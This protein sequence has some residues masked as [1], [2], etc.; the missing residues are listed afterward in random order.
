M[1]RRNFLKAGALASIPLLLKG[2]PV[3]AS[4]SLESETLD[5]IARATAGCG[6]IL[7]IVQM[8][9]GNDG[10][11]TVFPLDEWSSLFN[12][13]SNILMNQSS[14]LTLNNNTTTGLH[15][16]MSEMK[17]MY[18]N[19]K[20]MLVQAVSYPNPSFSHFRATD[21][22]FT[23]SD[24]SQTLNSGWIGRALD[25]M[26]PGYP[27]GY[28]TV[29][30]PDPLAIEIGSTLPFCLQGP[31]MNMGYSAPDPNSLLNVIN[32]ITDPAPNSDYG[33][34]LA[35]LRL[36]KDQSNVYRTAIQNAY[37]T[38]QAQSATYP[39]NNSLGDQLKIVAKLINGGLQ[40]PIYI[41]NH[42]KTHDTHENQVDSSDKTQGTHADN[43]KI[44]SQAISAFQRDLELMGKDQI[45]TGMTFSEFGRRIKS[46]ASNGTDHGSSA[47]VIFFGAAL[48]TN[49]ANVA[50]TPYPV[51]G[52][53]GT[54]PLLPASATVND[55][56]PMQFD[57]RQIY[58]T[59]MQDWLCM[60]KAD[61][62]AV[63]GGSFTKLPIF[64]SFVLPVELLFFTGKAEGSVAVLQW[65]TASEKNNY[66]FEIERSSNAVEFVKIGELL[67]VGTTTVEHD[68]TFIDELPLTGINYYRL[69]QIDENGTVNYSQIISVFFGDKSTL[70]IFPNPATDKITVQVQSNTTSGF[71]Q[72]Y[73]AFGNLQF[74][75]QLSQDNIQTQID[76][77]SLP[78]GNY[79]IRVQ[80][81]TNIITQHFVKL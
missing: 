61:A 73:D 52:M 78:K 77:A 46:N 62:D 13:R 20:L 32:G 14:V 74:E 10:L 75:K 54:S 6:K 60:S 18:D 27:V 39:L 51:P 57:F 49:L 79:F 53:I 34:E 56:V 35:F 3:F 63:L 31:N 9:G 19:G 2:V 38:T 59:I 76:I 30:M 50:S 36:M 1:Q 8:N 58:S 11:N 55:Q 7:V 37:N 23:A 16:A 25:K 21:I 45:V 4:N 69:K 71:T 64:Q 48:N 40:T 72:V 24:S 28:P 43:L 33:H 41:V 65:A 26:Y 15:P 5:T 44:L 29:A 66:K 42:P 80:S 12:A 17:T 67:G 47:P 68:Y 70:A 22:W 81:G